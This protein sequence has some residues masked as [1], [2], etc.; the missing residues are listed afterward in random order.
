MTHPPAKLMLQP[1]S[2]GSPGNSC[3]PFLKT[4]WGACSMDFG[5]R[6]PLPIFWFVCKET[7]PTSRPFTEPLRALAELFGKGSRYARLNTVFSITIF[8]YW[9]FRYTELQLE[10]G[11]ATFQRIPSDRLED[12]QTND[13]DAEYIKANKH[14]FCLLENPIE[15]NNV[16]K[17]SISH[18]KM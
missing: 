13:V 15:D 7:I 11:K 3:R 8:S 4:F 1:I 6:D 14:V 5:T 10:I 9:L 17:I 16:T 2:A 12:T 18:V